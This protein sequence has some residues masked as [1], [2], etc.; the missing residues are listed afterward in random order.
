MNK[1]KQSKAAASGIIP[2]A[3]APAPGTVAE[4]EEIAEVEEDV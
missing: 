1:E 2:E 3:A 4:A